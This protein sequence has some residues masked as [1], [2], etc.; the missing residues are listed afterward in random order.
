[1]NPRD[2][3]LQTGVAR[4]FWVLEPI[5]EPLDPVRHSLRED[6]IQV[7]FAN[8]IIVDVGWYPAF[9]LDGCF[10]LFLVRDQNWEEPLRR[11]DCSTLVELRELFGDFLAYA[12]SVRRSN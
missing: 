7:E 2:F 10:Q 9:S 8:G 4:V 6:L 11:A 12:R 3:D 5:A 1:M